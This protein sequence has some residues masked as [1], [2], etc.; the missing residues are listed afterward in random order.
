MGMPCC[1]ILDTNLA[2]VIK[3]KSLLG[4]AVGCGLRKMG[5]FFHRA[6]LDEPS[7]SIVNFLLFGLPYYLKSVLH[8]LAFAL[9]F[10]ILCFVCINLILSLTIM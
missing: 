5:N 9:C 2:L 4:E 10:F 7:I 8:N 6:F 3:T 1:L